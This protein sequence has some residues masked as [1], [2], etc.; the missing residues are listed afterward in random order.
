MTRTTAIKLLLIGFNDDNAEAIISTFRRAG[1]VAHSKIVVDGEQLQ[2]QLSS[3]RWDLAFFDGLRSSFAIGQCAQI[4]RH[5]NLDLPLIYLSDDET[6]PLPDPAVGLVLDIRNSSRLL[7]LCQRELDALE[8]RRQLEATKL[9]LLEEQQ[10]NALLL[11]AHQEAFCYITDGMVI[12]ANTLFCE[13]AGYEDL[14][15]FPIVDLISSKDQERFKNVLKKQTDSDESNTLDICFINSDDEEFKASARCNSASY[16][17]EPCVQLTLHDAGTE[18]ASGHLDATTGFANKKHFAHLLQDFV[19][20]QRSSNSSLI[21]I[22]LDNYDKYRRELKLQD[23]EALIEQLS[24]HLPSYIPGQHYGRIGDDLFAVI[25]HLVPCQRALEM[26]QDAL[27]TLETEIIEVKKQSLQCRCSAVVMPI[28][29][30]TTPHAATLL[31]QCFNTLLSIADKGGNAAEI[32]HR[33]RQQLQRS[34]AIS[35]LIDEAFA[36]QRLQVLFQPIINLSDA[37]GDYYEASLDIRNWQEGE[38]TAGEM[39]RVI[40]QEP[41]NNK[42][43]RWIVVE[44]TKMLAQKRA[45]G[46]DTKL[47]I[48]LSGNVFHD[49]EFCSWLSVAMKAAGLPGSALILQFSE[50]SIS[51]ALKPALNCC[52]QLEA[53]GIGLAVRNFGRSQD[54]N[55]FLKHIKPSLI[56][57]GIRKTDSLSSDEIKALIENG[58]SLNSRVLIPNVSSAAS[59]AVLWQLGPD[60]IQG[61]YVQDPSPEMDYEFAAFG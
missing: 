14:D 60:F 59:L 51:N 3:S 5:S 57:P 30:L 53:M 32:Y 6:I 35:E 26:S 9:A 45:R 29:H 21:V 41:D 28:N 31:D 12:Y 55:Q 15:G 48:N 54:G 1:R 25:A 37:S 23:S 20:T 7:H 18:A 38:V 27:A 39:L 11:D 24:K 17:G 50:E 43:D 8:N 36:D 52:R 16:D 33:E 44:T 42:L 13:R 40:E 4:L 2:Q 19:D 56:K 47:S 61:S 34:D 49:E 58:R 10:R 22:A 46:D